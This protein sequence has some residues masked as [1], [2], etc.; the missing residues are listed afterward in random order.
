MRSST[1]LCVLLAL[2]IAGVSHVLGSLRSTTKDIYP[3]VDLCSHGR[4]MACE[5]RGQK[6]CNMVSTCSSGWPHSPPCQETVNYGIASCVRGDAKCTVALPYQR[7]C[8]HGTHQIATCNN[9]EHGTQA[10]WGTVAGTSRRPS[11]HPLPPP[12]NPYTDFRR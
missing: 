3:H 10:P 6:R 2:V 5:L 9:P 4:P 1:S 8:S 12:P 7:P 11:S